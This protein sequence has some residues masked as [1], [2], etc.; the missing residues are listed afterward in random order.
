MSDASIDELAEALSEFDEPKKLEGRSAK[1]QRVLAGFEEI[2]RFVEQHGRAPQHGE[3]RDIFE[4]LYAVRLDRLRS[5]PECRD[6]LKDVDRR[7]LLGPDSA[8]G[9]DALA[10]EPDLDALAGSL[11]DLAE[12]GD[13]VT[14]LVHV[15]SPDEIRTAEE[16][17][18]REKCEDFDAFRSLFD[19][20][21]EQLAA[22]AR[23]VVPFKY[24]DSQAIEVGDWFVLD[25]QKTYVAGG[26]EPFIADHGERDRRLRVIYDN[27]TESNLLMRSLR[28]A[29]NKDEHSR[30]ILPPDVESAPLFADTIEDGD[31]QS[32]TI[33]VLRSKSNHPFIAK[34]RATI[35]KIGVT[36][37]E[38]KARI[39]NARK[40][41]TYLLADVEVAAEYKLANINR[42]ALEALLHRVFAAARLDL[43]IPDR[44]GGEVGP[45]EWFLVP[46]SAVDEAI[47]RIKDGS[48]HRYQYDPKSARFVST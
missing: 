17:A 45:T 25:G 36:G 10:A 3:D 48:I 8:A 39:S 19:Q 24:R 13:D 44:F 23:R 35:H 12:P 27:G 1:E 37:G 16:I 9:T 28:R 32:G 33:Y 26:G 41:P 34:H 31:L 5:L 22:K 47:S 15:R 43:V 14:R 29:L 40:D 20:V 30:R 4:R 38:V 46:E 18:Q 6:I 7:G 2:E 21:Q 42:N 11:A